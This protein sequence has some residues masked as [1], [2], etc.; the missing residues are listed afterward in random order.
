MPLAFRKIL[1]TCILGGTLLPLAA[2]PRTKSGDEWKPPAWH[3]GDWT[4]A[5]SG[6]PDQGAGSFSFQADL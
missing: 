4:G 6:A 2:R 5:G 1:A 3:V